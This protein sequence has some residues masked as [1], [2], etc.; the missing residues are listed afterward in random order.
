MKRFLVPLALLVLAACTQVAPTPNAQPDLTPLNFGAPGFD[1]AYGLAKHSTGVYVVGYT[2]GNLHPT[3]SGGDDAFVRKYST[4]GAVVWGR[5]FGT[6]DSDYAY[7]AASDSGNNVYVV[8]ETYG[9]IAGS[10]GGRDIF[11]RKYN[12]SGGVVWTRQLG[13]AG[14]DSAGNVATHGS[15]VYVAGT[16]QNASTGDFNAYLA[17]YSASGSLVWTRVFGS[18][19]EDED[20]G[21]DVITDGSGNAYIVGYTYGALGGTDGNGADMFIRRYN[22][23]G[24]SSWTLQ[25]DYSSYDYAQAVAFSGGNL[26]L[27]GHYYANSTNSVHSNARLIKLNTSGGV[28]WNRVYGSSLNE[29]VTDISVNGSVYFSGYTVDN[30]FTQFTGFVAKYNTSGAFFWRKNQSSPVEDFTNA[31]LAR[32][33]SEVYAA[34][35]TYGVLGGSNPD[36]DGDAFLR[37]LNG[38]NGNTV[39]THQ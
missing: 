33:S 24:S 25:F 10:R 22:A 4:N 31:V 27:V 23:N 9:N 35:Y 39:W 12:A 36:G 37:R 15:N 19:P 34:G 8:G 7:G 30:N 17:K 2:T 38:S 1:A 16:L 28:V 14:N 5:Q 21:K 29:V 20:W 11:L 32:T 3:P 18:S 6:S 26:Y 13:G